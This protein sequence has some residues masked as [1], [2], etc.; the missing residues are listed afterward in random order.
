MDPLTINHNHMKDPPKNKN[1][2]YASSSKC[3][4]CFVMI[5]WENCT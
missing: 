4:M 5:M 2:K 1:M 3:I